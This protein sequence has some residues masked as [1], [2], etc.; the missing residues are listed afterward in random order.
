MKNALPHIG[1]IRIDRIDR[2]PIIIISDT[3][4]IVVGVYERSTGTALVERHVRET[5]ET[6]R[7]IAYSCVLVQPLIT[8]VC[9]A[10][11]AF[12]NHIT[13][14][15]D[16]SNHQLKSSPSSPLRIPHPQRPSGT[17]VSTQ[18]FGNF[19]CVDQFE[20]TISVSRRYALQKRCKT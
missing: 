9:K 16:S 15:S 12:F 10:V 19:V 18:I 20:D 14:F 17:Y 8:A 6:N 5:A 4:N 2:V 1:L 11:A 3:C 7:G 13:V